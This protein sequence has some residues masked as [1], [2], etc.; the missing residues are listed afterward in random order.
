MSTQLGLGWPS[1]SPNTER[2]VNFLPSI[3]SLTPF[4]LISTRLVFADFCAPLRAEEFQWGLTNFD[5]SAFWVEDRQ[6]LIDAL[7]VTPEFL[8]TKQGDAGL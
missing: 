6:A 1:H 8:R 3:D 2:R 4:A 7:D 5:C